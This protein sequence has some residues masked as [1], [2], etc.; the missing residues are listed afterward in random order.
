MSDIPRI[1]RLQTGDVRAAWPHEARSF[2]PW[3]FDNLEELGQVVGMRLEPVE[4]E[5]AVDRF[6]ADIL[7]RNT[8][9]DN[10]VLIENQ[11]EESDHT[12][13]GQIMTYLAGLGANTVIWVATEFRES[14][15][16][17]L[18]WLN[19]HT[20]DDFSFFAVRIR[21]VR[22]ADS[23]F[24]ALFEVLARPNNWD[25]R[26]QATSAA[27]SGQ[28]EIGENRLEFWTVYVERVPGE[29]DRYGEPTRLSN[30]WRVLA[31]Q[32]LIISSYVAVSEVGIFVRSLRGGDARET[33]DWLLPHRELLEREL[34]ARL[35]GDDTKYF[36]VAAAPGDYKD[37]AQRDSLIEWL[38]GKADLYERTLR[39]IFPQGA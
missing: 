36:F 2:T 24:A 38:A 31:D 19:E 33:R 29:S 8:I 18:E 9:D 12:H 1:A 6:A 23:P 39:R 14:H 10:L 20:N 32:K 13:L 15:L 27:R 16:S 21:A 5:A 25:R 30:R 3:L 37:H 26:L 35:G 22:I 17:A 7:A 34:G 11:L 4:A 28:S